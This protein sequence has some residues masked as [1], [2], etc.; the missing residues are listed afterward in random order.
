VLCLR[1]ITSLNHKYFRSHV[2][3][4]LSLGWPLLIEDVG[5]Q[6]DPALDHILEKNFI[7]S[8]STLK[9][10]DYLCGASPRQFGSSASA[11]TTALA[12]VCVCQLQIGVLL[13]STDGSSWFLARMFP[14]T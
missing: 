7:R 11:G 8:G 9:V 5:E 14:S 2:E 4:S 6:L 1:Q 3:D 12:C 10:R 13:N